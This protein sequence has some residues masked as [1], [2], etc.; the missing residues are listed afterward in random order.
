MATRTG[1]LELVQKA[2]AICDLV[3]ETVKNWERFNLEV[4]G[5]QTIRAADSIGANIAESHG[6]YHYGEKIQFLL[7]A[8]GSLTET[9]YWLRRC[10]RRNLM[11]PAICQELDEKLE[12]LAK[13]INGYVNYL[14]N[15]RTNNP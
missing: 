10:L 2:E 9:Q 11:T 3:W 7:Y 8:R 15:R 4:M 1:D 14:R 5:S 13:D 12:S 6:R